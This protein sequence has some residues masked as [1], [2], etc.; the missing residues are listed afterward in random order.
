MGD[1][2]LEHEA[3]GLLRRWNESRSGSFVDSLPHFIPQAP[4]WQHNIHRLLN[5]TDCR[6]LTVALCCIF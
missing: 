1:L 3:Q 2:R 4:D 5:G 6:H